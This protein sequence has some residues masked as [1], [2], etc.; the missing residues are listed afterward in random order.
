MGRGPACCDPL[1]ITSDFVCRTCPTYEGWKEFCTPNDV[2]YDTTDYDYA[3]LITVNCDPSIVDCSVNSLGGSVSLGPYYEAQLSTGATYTDGND[4]EYTIYQQDSLDKDAW[5]PETLNE[6]RGKSR[7]SVLKET[8]RQGCPYSPSS[9]TSNSAKTGSTDDGGKLY[10][11][12]FSHKDYDLYSTRL[13]LAEAE[14]PTNCTATTSP[15]CRGLCAGY[16]P[17][18]LDTPKFCPSG[19]GYLLEIRSGKD[20]ID[21]GGQFF[22]C[23]T[24]LDQ[25]VPDNMVGYYIGYY[26]QNSPV[27]CV[28]QYNPNMSSGVPS[29]NSGQPS[30]IVSGT[31]LATSQEIISIIKNSFANSTTSCVYDPAKIYT[32]GNL[33]EDCDSNTRSNQGYNA[34]GQYHGPCNNIFSTTGQGCPRSSGIKG[35]TAYCHSAHASGQSN[36]YLGYQDTIDGLELGLKNPRLV[37]MKSF[38]DASIFKAICDPYD[39]ER[40]MKNGL[41]VFVDFDGLPA[42]LKS[43]SELD[44][45]YR[46]WG[47]DSSDA[48][49]VY[50]ALNGYTKDGRF[51]P[52]RLQYTYSTNAYVKPY[53]FPYRGNSNKRVDYGEQEYWWD[54]LN[55]KVMHLGLDVSVHMWR[56]QLYTGSKYGERTRMP[57]GKYIH[58]SNRDINEGIDRS[59]QCTPYHEQ[60]YC[61]NPVVGHGPNSRYAPE[62]YE[63]WYGGEPFIYFMENNVKHDCYL[64]V[65]KTTN[66]DTGEFE[67]EDIDYPEFDRAVFGNY[68]SLPEMPNDSWDDFLKYGDERSRNRCNIVAGNTIRPRY[69]PFTYGSLCYMEAQGI[70]PDLDDTRDWLM[71][72]H[73]PFAVTAS[74]DIDPPERPD[75][76]PF[77]CEFMV[78]NPDAQITLRFTMGDDP[79]EKIGYYDKYHD[80]YPDGQFVVPPFDGEEKLSNVLKDSNNCSQH[81]YDF[82][83]RSRYL[84]NK[85]T[86]LKSQKHEW[87]YS[88]KGCSWMENIEEW[89]EVNWYVG[90]DGRATTDIVCPTNN[91]S[92]GWGN[93][94][95]GSTAA[96]CNGVQTAPPPEFDDDGNLIPFDPSPPLSSNWFYS[97]SRVSTW[98]N[99]TGYNYGN[100]WFYG[101]CGLSEF[102]IRGGGNCSW[103][104]SYSNGY[105]LYNTTAPVAESSRYGT[106]FATLVGLFDC[107]EE[108]GGCGYCSSYTH[109]WRW[110]GNKPVT[111]KLSVTYYEEGPNTCSIQYTPSYSIS[112]GRW[113]NSRNLNGVFCA[114]GRGGVREWICPPDSPRACTN[115]D[116]VPQYD[117]DVWY[118]AAG[119]EVPESWEELY[120]CEGTTNPGCRYAQLDTCDRGWNKLI[121]YPECKCPPPC[122]T[123]PEDYDNSYGYAGWQCMTQMNTLE[124]IEFYGND[125]LSRVYAG[126]WRGYHNWSY[127]NLFVVEG[128]PKPDSFNPPILEDVWDF[129]QGVGFS[130]EGTVHINAHADEIIDLETGSPAESAAPTMMASMETVYLY[131]LSDKTFIGFQED[132][133]DPDND[134]PTDDKTP[135]YRDNPFSSLTIPFTQNGS[136]SGEVRAGT[137]LL[138]GD[139]IEFADDTD[140]RVIAD[141]LSRKQSFLD[142]RFLPGGGGSN[143]GDS[144]TDS[145]GNG[146]PDLYEAS[147]IEYTDGYVSNAA[148]AGDIELDLANGF[149]WR[150]GSRPGEVVQRA[151]TP[152][153][154]IRGF[155]YRWDAREWTTTVHIAYVSSVTFRRTFELGTDYDIHGSASCGNEWAC[156]NKCGNRNLGWYHSDWSSAPTY[157]VP[158]EDRDEIW[159]TTPPTLNNVRTRGCQN[160]PDDAVQAS[161]GQTNG[162]GGGAI[163]YHEDGSTIRPGSADFR[164]HAFYD[165]LA[166]AERSG[167]SKQTI[168]SLELVSG[169]LNTKEQTFRVQIGDAYASYTVDV[170]RITLDC[171]D[172]NPDREDEQN[173]GG[174]SW[175]SNSTWGSL[176]SYGGY[177]TAYGWTNTNRVIIGE[178]PS[179]DCEICSDGNQAS[180]DSAWYQLSSQST[181]YYT[182]NDY[183]SCSSGWHSGNGNA[184]MPCNAYRGPANLRYSSYRGYGYYTGVYR[185]SAYGLGITGVSGG[186]GEEPE[187]PPCWNIGGGF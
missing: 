70:S 114:Y 184:S 68:D 116:P 14:K 67:Y 122:P 76:I 172:F 34:Y 115:Y 149:L 97:Q 59:G 65:E 77:G 30:R 96:G 173:F 132:I 91:Y 22:G 69:A 130:S 45:V 182:G 53:A 81:Y 21:N 56:T 74:V 101:A 49:T 15:D 152:S 175:T 103:G 27:G 141:V 107:A 166:G 52:G 40:C 150:A 75:N 80:L 129:A 90:C 167:W 83:K 133:D 176:D 84:T 98:G 32:L 92:N 18:G 28:T 171:Y 142:T 177:Y 86:H 155:A 111:E 94:G 9:S 108:D 104:Y 63:S 37:P 145:N 135:V 42:S 6:H 16:V 85:I 140:V 118:Q 1:E 8:Y 79:N 19:D 181:G 160:D 87:S 134:I 187:K 159:N 78:C 17:P 164:S 50:G 10:I 131:R 102:W 29:E 20:C 139:P 36:E 12:S 60:T 151:W 162:A 112:Y 137:W 58:K 161:F 125:S 24:D 180:T 66:P 121:N 99:D 124:A 13:N 25:N 110:N 3:I 33:R 153:I 100:S 154:P 128:E 106:Y 105:L 54:G 44:M 35:C 51:Y 169:T 109:A 39:R 2:E 158:C 186:D 46:N 48:I 144:T 82:Y 179:I 183:A 146:I 72:K 123:E 31:L 143:P 127:L 168:D 62:G 64:N 113:Y 23:D 73:V 163:G 170:R 185:I 156:G 38:I 11:P 47:D 61:G 7:M 157:C 5:V 174:E 117:E 26:D 57:I 147:V 165:A 95:C 4:N 120:Y 136:E 41:G 178:K 138:D 55:Y 89:H 93:P 88:E 43:P 148:S 71:G 119:L 126:G